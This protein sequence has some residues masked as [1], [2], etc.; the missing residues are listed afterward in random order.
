VVLRSDEQAQKTV[1]ELM[2]KNAESRFK[3]IKEKAE[4]VQDLDV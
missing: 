2:G 3:F 4:F 1:S